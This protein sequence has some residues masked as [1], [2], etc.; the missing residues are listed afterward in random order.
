MAQMGQIHGNLICFRINSLQLFFLTNCQT[1]LRHEIVPRGTI[2][3]PRALAIKNLPTEIP[4]DGK[5]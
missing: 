5:V 3:V 1:P 2:C 4:P